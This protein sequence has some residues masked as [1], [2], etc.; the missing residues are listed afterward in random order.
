[1]LSKTKAITCANTIGRRMA[2]MSNDSEI[3]DVLR[4]PYAYENF[5]E[6]DIKN[7][8]SKLIPENMWAIYH[9]PLVKEEKDQNPEKFTQ[10]RWYSKDFTTE[11]LS[12]EFKTHLKLV[13]PEPN[14]KMGNAPINKFMPKAENLKTLKAERANPDKPG[15]P[16]IIDMGTNDNF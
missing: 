3:D 11:I 9:S 6:N 10:E 5:D 1:M 14:M 15:L 7:R 4:T 16:K 2:Y 13:M 12:N 8:I